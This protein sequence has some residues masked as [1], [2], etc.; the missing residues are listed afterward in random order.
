MSAHHLR[1]R[2]LS[3]LVACERAADQR[4]FAG[5]SAMAW[6]PLI[7][8]AVIAASAAQGVIDTRHELFGHPSVYVVDPSAIPVNLGVNPSLTITA[9][10]ERFASLIPPR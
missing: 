1:R 3:R 8:G 9:L 7:G 6:L 4:S 2:H 5:C 10:A